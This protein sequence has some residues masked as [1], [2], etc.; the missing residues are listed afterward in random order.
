MRTS[1]KSG[2]TLVELLVVIAIIGILMGLLLPAVQ[3]AREAARRAQCLNNMR[4]IGLAAFNYE[5]SKQH[6][7][8]AGGC[9]ETYWAEQNAP[10]NG[11]QNA[12]WGFQ[13]LPYIEQDNLYQLRNGNGW[14]GGP[15]SLARTRI[16]GYN[17]PSRGERVANLGWT[18]VALGDYAGVMA[19]WNDHLGRSN[20]QW[21]FEWNNAANVNPAETAGFVWTGIIS[22]DS[23]TNV[24]TTPVTVTK[25]PKVRIATVTDGTSNTIMFME[26]GVDQNNWSINVGAW[27]WWDLMGYHHNADWANMRM[28][29]VKPMNDSTTRP[30]YT[31]ISGNSDNRYTEFGFGSP[32]SGLMNAV[33]G[34]GSTR[35]FDIDIDLTVLDFVGQ[36]SDKQVVDSSAL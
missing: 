35:N 9:S 7:P 12:G 6:Y 29:D 1:R 19:S 21:G 16:P 22:K 28:P 3:Q 4:Q 13:L 5:S 31:W 17:C 26:K 25:L 33:M 36:R 11:F 23:H 20:F 18:T 14:F 32:H 15:S 24:T 10:A 27:D 2:F 30:Y 34:D 8:T